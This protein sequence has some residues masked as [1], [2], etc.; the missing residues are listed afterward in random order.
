[1]RVRYKP[2]GQLG[3]IPDNKFDPSLFEKVQDSSKNTQ[4][5]ETLQGK[6]GKF[7]IDSLLGI[8]SPFI[9]TG[10]NVGGAGVEAAR[11]SGIEQTKQ[12]STGLIDQS[13]LINQQLR[14]ETD[15]LKKAALLEQSRKLSE[16]LGSLS[17]TNKSI[18]QYQNPF[19][20]KEDM[21]QVIE[22]PVEEVARNTAGLASFAIDPTKGNILMQILKSAAQGGL[23]TASQKG[24]GAAEIA[25]GSVF[26]GALGGLLGIGGKIFGG[27]GSKVATDTLGKELQAVA[28]QTRNK[29]LGQV[30]A[31]A[32]EDISGSVLN[33][34]AREGVGYIADKKGLQQLQKQLDLSGHADSQLEQL[35]NQFNLIQSKIKSLLSGNKTEALTSTTIKDFKEELIKT[36]TTPSD[37]ASRGAILFIENRIK[38]TANKGSITAEA[39]YQLKSD[40][41]GELTAAMTKIER[42]GV[43]QAKEEAKL[44]AFNSLKKTLDSLDKNIM[45][46]NSLENKMFDLSKGLIETSK[47]VKGSDWLTN[48]LSSKGSQA[49]ADVAGQTTTKVGNTLDSLLRNPAS[50][51]MK[52][53]INAAERIPGQIQQGLVSGAGMQQGS[54]I[55]NELQSTPD[56]LLKTEIGDVT[57]NEKIKQLLSL[58]ALYDLS[59]NNGRDASKIDT[60]SKMFGDKIGGKKTEAEQSASSTGVSTKDAISQLP[61]IKSKVGLWGI[62]MKTNSLL[63]GANMADQDVLDFVTTIGNIKASIAKARA[64]TSFTANEEKMLDKYT[65]NENDSYQSLQTKLKWLDRNF[66]NRIIK[67]NE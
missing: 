34:K 32:G 13:A 56:E 24:T 2:T 11:A 36:M 61:K 52:R 49:V 19:L 48:I 62:G 46:Y 43:L 59:K 40:L 39:L 38:S 67:S 22:H 51:L 9:K 50:Q 37:K 42:G 33:P 28:S 16:G 6:A 64:G 4:Q 18:T 3:D 23:M 65:P 26:S 60:V 29:N 63:S 58:A 55:Q 31:G 54:D 45:P 57:G 47:G 1:M 17:Q 14:T 12:A 7:V 5:P 30:I 25:G 44:A 15:P 53:G 20:N 8:A 35:G 27:R 21:K 10:Q 66:S 41:R